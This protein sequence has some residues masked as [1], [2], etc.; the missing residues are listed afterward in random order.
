MKLINIQENAAALRAAIEEIPSGDER[1]A[2]AAA[3]A[4]LTLLEAFLVDVRRIADAHGGRLS[5]GDPVLKR[6]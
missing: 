6:K 4:A 2:K 3:N 5:I 1:A